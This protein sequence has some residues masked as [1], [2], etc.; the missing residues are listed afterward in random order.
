MTPAFRQQDYAGGL[1]AAAQRL[2]RLID[3][4]ALPPPRDPLEPGAVRQTLAIAFLLG[5]LGGVALLVRPRAWYW[6]LGAVVAL[7]AALA[8][9]R[10]WPAGAMVALAEM[11]AVLGVGF[12]ALLKYSRGA[13]W[14]FAILVLYALGLF[15]A[16]RRYGLPVLHYGL[17]VP[18]SLG[19]TLLMLAGAW[20]GLRRGRRWALPAGPARPAADPGP[21]VPAVAGGRPAEQHRGADHPARRLPAAAH[22]LQFQRRRLGEG[23]D[24]AAITLAHRVPRRR[25]R[26]VRLRTR[27][28][29]AE[30]RVAVVAPP[31]VG[32]WRKPFFNQ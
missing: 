13:R 17:A 2:V 7:A 10:H 19:L 30:A 12:G 14:F 1:E 25:V 8:L 3:G 29:A 26:P 32:D 24:A 15:W 28:P 11:V 23:V 31:A 21:G 22:R 27:S 20:Q 5:A 9:G 6:T 18:L 4:E 16:Y